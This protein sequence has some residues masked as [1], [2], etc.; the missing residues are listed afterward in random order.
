MSCKNSQF[1]ANEDNTRL[2]ILYP[3]CGCVLHSPLGKRDGK[4]QRD[5]LPL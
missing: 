3:D 5:V 4:K 2:V 1:V